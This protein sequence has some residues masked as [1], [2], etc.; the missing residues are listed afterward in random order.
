MEKTAAR[1][2]KE[3]MAICMIKT[4]ISIISLFSTKY[5]SKIKLY[6]PAPQVNTNF[7]VVVIEGNIHLA[8]NV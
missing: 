7:D 1:G 5:H 2:T 6:P 3:R 4:R 8:N